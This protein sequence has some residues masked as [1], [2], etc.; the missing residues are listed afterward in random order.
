MRRIL[1]SFVNVVLPDCILTLQDMNIK[2]REVEL[3]S[4]IWI[5]YFFSNNNLAPSLIK[6]HL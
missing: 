6:L 4:V 3:Q 2:L 1:R 5:T